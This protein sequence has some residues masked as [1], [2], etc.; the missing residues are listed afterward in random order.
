MPQQL[1]G[2]VSCVQSSSGFAVSKPTEVVGAIPLT[3][4][5]N[6][7][8]F[9]DKLGLIKSSPQGSRLGFTWTTLECKNIIALLG[10]GGLVASPMN[11]FLPMAILLFRT[12]QHCTATGPV[13]TQR[14]H[15]FRRKSQKAERLQTFSCSPHLANKKAPQG[16]KR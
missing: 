15:G 13:L 14:L 3:F 1:S 5:S 11:W 12:E 10:I 16:S 2:H 9:G 7:R 8:K 4:R 6:I